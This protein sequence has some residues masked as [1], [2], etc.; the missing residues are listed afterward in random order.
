[1]DNR[2]KEGYITL[3]SPLSSIQKHW[4]RGTWIPEEYT[5]PIKQMRVKN[6]KTGK[7]HNITRLIVNPKMGFSVYE[8]SCNQWLSP[9]ESLVPTTEPLTCKV[10]IRKE[11][12]Y[13]D[14]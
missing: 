10:C 2:D 14:R 13:N 3:P 9:I 12:K 4:G 11:E 6:T 8:G 1:M 7:I 5:I